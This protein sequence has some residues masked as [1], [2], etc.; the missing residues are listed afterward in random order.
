[1]PQ[2][3]GRKRE[4]RYWQ[5]R[6]LEQLGRQQEAE[7]IYASLAQI[8]TYYGFLATDRL[9]LPYR[10]E[11]QRLDLTEEY[12]QSLLNRSA[13]L[14]AREYLYVGLVLE[15]RR[16]WNKALKG[17]GRE[18]LKAAAVLADRW[19]WHERAVF[20]VARAAH[21]SDF[22]L[23]FPMPFEGQVRKMSS[24]HQ[25]DPA[26]IYSVIRKESAYM[27]DATSRAGAVGLMQLMPATARTVAQRL[28]RPLTLSDLSDVDTN[29]ELGSYYLRSVMDKFNDQQ[30]LAAAAYNAGPH[31]VDRWL[32]DGQSLPADVWVDTIPYRETRGYVRAVLAYTI[33]F[34]WRIAGMAKPLKLRMAEVV[35]KNSLAKSDAC[36]GTPQAET[37]QTGTC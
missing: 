13:I 1:M 9:G 37:G 18:Q 28:G 10:I 15:A 30:S 17:L 26:L 27:A 12:Q 35:A 23:R 14:R 6:A 21:S 5:A 2:R 24:Q 11:S 16:E 7:F 33:I 3:L 8:P 25:L 29:I 4:W 36:G 32:P 19:G 20:T 31:R 22:K 34:E